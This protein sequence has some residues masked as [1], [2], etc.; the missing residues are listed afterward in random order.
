MLRS[1][2]F[3]KPPKTPLWFSKFSKLQESVYLVPSNAKSIKANLH[4]Y[5]QELSIGTSSRYYPNACGH[6]YDHG[7]RV[8]G[9]PVD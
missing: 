8:Q 3:K 5:N 2:E 7:L 4:I 6:G 1:K 9:L